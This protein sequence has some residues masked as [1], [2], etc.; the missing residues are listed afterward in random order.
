MLVSQTSG[1]GQCKCRGA[2]VVC[3]SL[4]TGHLSRARKNYPELF[5]LGFNPTSKPHLPQDVPPP[6][7]LGVGVKLWG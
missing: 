6:S 1:R 3:G 5:Y 4:T 2:K 7:A